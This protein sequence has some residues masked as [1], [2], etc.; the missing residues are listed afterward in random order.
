MKASA[1][2]RKGQ[3]KMNYDSKITGQIIGILRSQKG[4]SQE[5]LSGLAG[6]ARSHL[7]MIE[8]G[9]KNAN[10]NTLWR[11]SL[12]LGIRLSDLIRMVES[13]IERQE[14]YAKEQETDDRS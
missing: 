3:R 8:N 5:V 6:V 13:E 7:S 1:Y 12:A 2:Q 11:V 9:S 4:M 10:V 14:M